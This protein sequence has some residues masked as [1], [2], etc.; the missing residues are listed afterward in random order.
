MRATAFAVCLSILSWA[1]V[2]AQAP[3]APAS[4]KVATPKVVVMPYVQPGP[5]P[6]SAGMDAMRVYWFTDQTPGHF[7]VEYALPDGVWRTAMPSRIPLDFA[8]F[9]P[10]PPKKKDPSK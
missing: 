3:S 5:G 2:R 7:A 1:P 4:A 8:K 9:I 6:A 10:E